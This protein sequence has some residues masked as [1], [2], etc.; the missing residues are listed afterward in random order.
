MAPFARTQASG[1]TDVAA[2]VAASKVVTVLTYLHGVREAG[3]ALPTIQAA[4]LD[5]DEMGV[6]RAQRALPRFPRFPRFGE[7]PP[8][9]R[10]VW[11]RKR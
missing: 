4:G 2:A 9:R 11:S 8:T 1:R 10:N 7:V 5:V 3:N 6:A